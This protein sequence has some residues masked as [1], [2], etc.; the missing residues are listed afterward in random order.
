MT[1]IN[2]FKE[3]YDMQTHIAEDVVNLLKDYI[4]FGYSKVI[5]KKAADKGR[6]VTAQKV[7]NVKNFIED[8]LHILNLLIEYA[9]ENKAV[10]DA[11]KQK[12]NELT[13]K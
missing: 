4:P 13:S 2:K 10:A 6:T 1:N 11:E 12:F 8:D 7:R 9:K 5:K 3:L